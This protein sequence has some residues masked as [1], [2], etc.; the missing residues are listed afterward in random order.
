MNM[1]FQFVSIIFSIFLFLSSIHCGEFIE[2]KDF[3][4]KCQEK[5]QTACTSNPG[6]FN[7]KIAHTNL[8]DKTKPIIGKDELQF[9][10]NLVIGTVKIYT[11]AETTYL[12]RR[13]KLK[14]YFGYEDVLQSKYDQ[15]IETSKAL[16]ACEQICSDLK[17]FST[18]KIEFDISDIKNLFAELFTKSFPE[19]SGLK[20]EAIITEIPVQ[21]NSNRR[22]LKQVVHKSQRSFGERRLVGTSLQFVFNLNTATQKSI[23]QINIAQVNSMSFVINVKVNNQ[24]SA[25]TFISFLD[26]IERVQEYIQALIDQLKEVPV[27]QD[28][29]SDELESLTQELLDRIKCENPKAMVTKT[30]QFTA[31]IWKKADNVIAADVEELEGFRTARRLANDIC[32]FNILTISFV[33]I[34]VDGFPNLEIY[35]EGNNEF[36]EPI[37][38]DYLLSI[39]TKEKTLNRI[40][41]LWDKFVTIFGE[42][43]VKREIQKGKDQEFDQKIIEF[44]NKVKNG[45]QGLKIPEKNEPALMKGAQAIQEVQKRVKSAFEQSGSKSQLD[46]REELDDAKANY[47]SVFVNS[48]R[49]ISV[50]V[51]KEKQPAMIIMNFFGFV[52]DDGTQISSYQIEV[53]TD[54]KLNQFAILEKELQTFFKVKKRELKIAI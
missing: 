33:K 45:E 54:E 39:E 12:N 27:P 21:E 29:T 4:I 24:Y 25:K 2:Y 49:A 53:T 40:K 7:L 51:Q 3:V 14:G 46:F 11:V 18:S 32:L 50:E 35:F 47:F 43:D 9:E 31:T 23:G 28:I 36:L 26:K 15:Q 42:N 10:T 37:R 1:N 19:N 48:K 17:Q 13:F 44:Y 16:P 22:I 41:T 52:Q 20:L 34:K 38:L 30:D 8:F 5:F 6:E